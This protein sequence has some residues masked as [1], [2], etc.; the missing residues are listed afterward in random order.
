MQGKDG[1]AREAYQHCLEIDPDHGRAR[2]ALA[3]LGAKTEADG[4]S[5][6]TG[7]EPQ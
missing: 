7:T 2:E 4:K 5:E 1:P 3:A 6:K